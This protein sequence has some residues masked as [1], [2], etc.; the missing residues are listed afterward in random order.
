VALFNFD[1]KSYHKAMDVNPLLHNID[2][3]LYRISA[4]AIIIEYGKVLLIKEDDDGWWSFPGGGIDLGEDAIKALYREL[5]E[6]LGLEPNSIKTNGKIVHFVVG[7]IKDGI[8]RANIFY[9]TQVKSEKVKTTEH[10]T[11]FKWHEPDELL[12][13]YI[14]PSSGDIIQLIEVINTLTKELL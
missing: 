13:L 7:H 8:P 5:G 12:D 2:N 9:H 14:S 3:C 1:I 10:V 4:K 6:E 11:Q